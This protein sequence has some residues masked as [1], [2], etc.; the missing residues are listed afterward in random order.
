MADAAGIHREMFDA[1]QAQDFE[2]LRSL[3]HP[4][5]WYLGAD[6]SEGG[7]DAALDVAETYTEAFPDLAFE[8]RHQFQPSGDVSIIEM[9]ARGTHDGPLDDIPPT[10]RAVEMLVC[11]VVEVSDGK[12]VQEREYF[13]T[14]AIMNQLG[15]DD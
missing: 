4:D 3:L 10:G 8:I 7:I 2:R 11:N 14:L 6:G 5:Y 13:D 1:I 15:V 9:T 12:I